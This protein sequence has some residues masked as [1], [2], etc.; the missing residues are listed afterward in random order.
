MV[1]H[2]SSTNKEIPH[3][4]AWRLSSTRFSSLFGLIGFLF[5]YCNTKASTK[6]MF[7]LVKFY[8]FNIVFSESDQIYGFNRIESEIAESVD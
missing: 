5:L 3:H 4:H 1:F 6:F 2:E 7:I 8:W